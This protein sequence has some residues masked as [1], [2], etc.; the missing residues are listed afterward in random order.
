LPNVGT[1]KMA[2]LLAVTARYAR[3]SSTERRSVEC[4]AGRA[5]AKL[6]MTAQL[7][8]S[9]DRTTSE[10]LLTSK[11]ALSIGHPSWTPRALKHNPNK[12]AT[13]AGSP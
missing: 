3:L 12:D 6:V 11:F 8:F 10:H 4:R 2:A 1:G 9:L 5:H 7:V 13:I